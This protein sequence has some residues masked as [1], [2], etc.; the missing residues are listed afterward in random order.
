MICIVSLILLADHLLES[1]ALAITQSYTCL[2][3]NICSTCFSIVLLTS[4]LNKEVVVDRLVV[5]KKP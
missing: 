2:W 1:K 4:T 3:E 5:N